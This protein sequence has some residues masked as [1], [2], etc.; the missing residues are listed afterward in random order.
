MY[1]AANIASACLQCKKGE[2]NFPRVLRARLRTLVEK[3][4]E[5]EKKKGADALAKA[6]ER[7]NTF[8]RQ[9][10]TAL[11]E[12]DTIQFDEEQLQRLEAAAALFDK[13]PPGDA[14][15]AEPE[16]QSMSSVTIEVPVVLGPG[17]TPPF[18][19]VPEFEVR[20]RQ[21]V[22][23]QRLI[24]GLSESGETA[25]GPGPAYAVENAAGAIAWL[26]KQ[27]GD[28]MQAVME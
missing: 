3:V 2:C 1:N 25:P 6:N 18:Y 12:P 7:A 11:G 23:L 15:V 26:L 9:L 21:A 4:Q 10:A 14:P 5:Y 13:G 24:E 17:T 22:V 8:I 28:Q 27:I 16:K 19:C 20:G